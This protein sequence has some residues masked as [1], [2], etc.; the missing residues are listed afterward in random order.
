MYEKLTERARRAVVWSE[1]HARRRGHDYVDTEHLL[2]ALLDDETST[3]YRVLVSL[4]F[5]V[6]LCRR[7]L[8][9][10]TDRGGQAHE[11]PVPLSER[12]KVVH[13]VAGGWATQHDHRHIGTEH[14]LLALTQE[15]D[16]VV[17]RLFSSLGLTGNLVVEKILALRKLETP[18]LK[19]LG[20]KPQ[21]PVPPAQPTRR[22]AKVFV[23]YR[24][25]PDSHVAGRIAD[26]IDRHVDHA[27]VF[28]DVDSIQLGA[29]FTKAINAAV[30][31]CDVLIAV[32]GH[33]WA[34][35]TDARGRVRLEQ[36]NDL[37]RLE[38]E[39]ALH[40][41]VRVVPVLVDGAEMPAFDELPDSLRS[42]A[43]RHGLKIRH[44]SFRQDIARLAEA[45]I[46]A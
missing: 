39:A 11:R 28:M 6:V 7:H 2:L 34:T 25:V 26:W 35:A 22:V 3:A 20:P 29:D 31:D 15:K 38:I 46:R 18:Q 27:E 19:A 10:V 16:G 45:V 32:I 36:P 8:L 33:N 9:K 14:L 13:R 43:F 40:R 44:D 37:V 12:A 4:R 24:R 21:P 41:D 17:G 1:N 5:P 42:L 23:S 30:S